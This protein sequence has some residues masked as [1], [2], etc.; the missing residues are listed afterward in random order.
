MNSKGKTILERV[1]L[2]IANLELLAE[3]PNFEAVYATPT[4]FTVPARLKLSPK[5]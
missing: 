4:V 1:A 2:I 5:R 3:N